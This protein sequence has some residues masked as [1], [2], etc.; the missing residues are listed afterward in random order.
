V[1]GFL[2]DLGERASIYTP[3]ETTVARACFNALLTGSP[4]G[5]PDLLSRLAAPAE[6]VTRILA[7]LEQ[8]GVLAVDSDGVTVARGLSRLPTAHRLSVNAGPDVFAC[9]AIDAIGI[10]AALG[11]DALVTSRC[12]ACM[13]PIAITIAGGRLVNP[14]ATII[15]WAAD[16]D[17]ARSLREYT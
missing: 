2:D 15:I 16:T 8:K 1:A 11:D 14:S 9:C 5:I 3:E 10:P 12:H 4:A 17:P 6:A 7:A 13:A